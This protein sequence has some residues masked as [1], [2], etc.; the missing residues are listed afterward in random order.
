[1]NT[2]IQKFNEL[3]NIPS[4]INE[5]LDALAEYASKCNHVTEIGVRGIVS[6]WAFLKGNPQTLISYDLKHPNECGGNLE[7]VITAAKEGNINFSFIIGD[8]TKITIDNTDLLFIDTWH[9]YDQ[10]NKE[11]NLHKNNV[12][13][14]IVLHDT[15]L[16]E[17]IDESFERINSWNQFFVGGGLWKAVEEFLNTN[18]EWVIEKRFTHNNGLTI[19]KKI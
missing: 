18:P 12:N 16:Y 17:K 10:L 5:H 19:L 9:T 7:E 8:S 4:D 14:Y 13:K 6:T 3:K 15:T 1:M 11:L 2:I